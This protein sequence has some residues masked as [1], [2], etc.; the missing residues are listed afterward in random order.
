MADDE[1]RE[2]LVNLLV[3]RQAHMTFE[4]AV[5]NFPEAW[6]NGRAPAV[7]YTFWHLL[8]HLRISQYDILDYIRNPAYEELDFPDD[9][10]PAREA[11]T[12]RAGWQATIDQFLADR[13]ALVDIVRDPATDLLAQIPHGWE[14]HNVLREILV[15]ADHNA[16]H[17]GEL[18][19]LRQVVGCW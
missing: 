16:Y 14:G 3:K 17:V 10:W 1:L 13:Q 15:V 19:I 5:A 4:D 12:D 8:E 2:Q 18:G 11:E 9:L 6:I 7:P